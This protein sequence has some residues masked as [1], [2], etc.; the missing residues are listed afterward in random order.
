MEYA[1]MDR[2][3]RPLVVAYRLEDSSEIRK[4]WW[5]H[6]MEY[7]ADTVYD[8]VMSYIS[9]DRR[10]PTIADIV[11]ICETLKNSRRRIPQQNGKTVRCPYCKD[12]GLVYKETPT[13]ILE[14]HPCDQCPKGRE[15]F[16]WPFLSPEEQQA[17]RESEAKKGRVVPIPHE[18]SDEFRRQYLYGEESK[19]DKVKVPEL[20]KLLGRR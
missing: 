13:G 14:A 4:V 1:E 15:R 16:P 20:E 18:A 9:T 2:V 12:L 17:W 10:I 19:M 5:T 6:L 7:D 11:G 8:A 3:Y